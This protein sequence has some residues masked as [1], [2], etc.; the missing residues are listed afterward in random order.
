MVKLNGD[1]I[2]HR[3]LNGKKDTAT[4]FDSL[5]LAKD[6][7]DLLSDFLQAYQSSDIF[8]LRDDN[9]DSP[10]R[11]F[12]FAWEIDDNFVEKYQGYRQ[13]ITAAE[14]IASETEILVVIGYSFPVF[15]REVDNRLFQK[16]KNLSKVYIQDTDPEKI[17]STMKNAFEVLQKQEKTRRS[18]DLVEEIKDK[19][20]FHLDKNV[21][22]FIIPYELM[23]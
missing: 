21:N 11:Y 14:K 1:A 8:D 16:M 7:V 19:V 23:Q 10:F 5:D 17:K 18:V 20:E 9:N 12:N 2:W 4:I 13:N 6:N 15:N 22:Q 3:E